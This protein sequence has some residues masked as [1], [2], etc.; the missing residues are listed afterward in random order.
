[1][2]SPVPIRVCQRGGCTAVI[3]KR[4]N[5]SIKDYLKQKFCSRECSELTRRHIQHTKSCECGSVLPHY[6][7]GMCW[8]CYSKA[9]YGKN[10]S[11]GSVHPKQRIDA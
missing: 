4:R 5:R 8:V 2:P 1:M 10:L 6:A 3:P 9:V 11:P 7:R